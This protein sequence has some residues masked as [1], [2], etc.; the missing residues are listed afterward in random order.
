[1]SL[2]ITG[3]FTGP[4]GIKLAIPGFWDGGNR[5]KLRFTPTVA[6]QWHY[7]VSASDPDDD[8]PVEDAIRDLIERARVSG[9]VTW[10][11]P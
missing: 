1:M 2:L 8:S 9:V 5:W 6:G 11:R 3:S 4:G 10:P 7:A